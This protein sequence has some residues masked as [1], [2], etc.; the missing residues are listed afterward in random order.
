L[1]CLC[2]RIAFPTKFPSKSTPTWPAT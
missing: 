1:A 2:R